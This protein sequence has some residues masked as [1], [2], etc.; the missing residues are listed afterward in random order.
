MKNPHRENSNFLIRDLPKSERPREKLLNRGPEN[1]K[2]EELLAILIGT[3]FHG[4]SALKLARQILAKYP[5]NKLLKIQPNQLTEIKGIGSSKASIILAAIELVKRSLNLREE[6]IPV[7]Q[8][9]KD[10][11][12][13]VSFLRD[14]QREHFVVLFLNARNQ[15]ITKKDL[16]I[17]TLNANLVHPREIFSEALKH[18][19]ASLILIHN[20]PSGDPEPSQD[21]LEITKRLREAGQIMGLEIIDHLI[22]SHNNYFSFK[23]H[24]LLES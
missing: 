18:N 23:E 2:D 12:S 7:I 8:S 19:A 13:Q 10:V 3:G 4:K 6:T 15:L 9:P 16:F 11:I 1:L 20:H 24:Q 5:K 14:K 17:G 21:D 22:I